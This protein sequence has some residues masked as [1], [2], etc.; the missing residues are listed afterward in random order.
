MRKTF[1]KKVY[2][3][4]YMCMCVGV[5]VPVTVTETCIGLEYRKG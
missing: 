5:H 4:V 3:Y 1:Q 2:E